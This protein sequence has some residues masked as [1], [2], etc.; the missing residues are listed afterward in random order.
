M[1]IIF[2]RHGETQF[3]LEDRFQGI[4]NSPLTNKGIEQAQ[5]F[6]DLLM[7]DFNIKEFYLSP[8]LRVIQTFE[9]ASASIKAGH[10][11]ESRL[12]ECCYGLID[13]KR[14]QEIPTEI[15]EDREKSRF[16]YIH[17]GKFQGI[18]GESYHDVYLRVK[19]FMEELI[20][21]SRTKDYD[22]SIISHNGV[23]MGIKKFFQNISDDE[24]NKLRISNKDYFVWNSEDNSFISSSI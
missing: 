2:I 9:I 21:N 6:N 5:K 20:T 1:K 15:L 14:R 24:M 12:R 8:A 11:L 19:L 13:G 7:K 4:A 17:Q 10:T 16:T 22:I 3:N 18:S 23:M